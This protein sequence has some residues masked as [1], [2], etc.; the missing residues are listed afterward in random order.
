MSLTNTFS[1]VH[2]NVFDVLNKLTIFRINNLLIEHKNELIT[3]FH[4]HGIS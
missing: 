2:W 3:D 4:L 1:M